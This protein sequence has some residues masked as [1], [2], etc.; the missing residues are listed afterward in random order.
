[1]L[2]GLVVDD[3]DIVSWV[4]G[5]DGCLFGCSEEQVEVCGVLVVV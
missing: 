4:D 5:G 3:V 1:M 2:M